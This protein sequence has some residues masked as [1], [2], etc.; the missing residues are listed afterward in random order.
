GWLVGLGAA[1]VSLPA[2]AQDAAPAAPPPPAPAMAPAPMA[3]APMPAAAAPT[4]APDAAKSS[5]TVGGHIGVATSFVTF[6]SE[7]KTIGDRFGLDNPIGV[8]VKFPSG[9]VVDFET[10]V[11]T[12]VLPK[13]STGFT[14][15]PGVVYNWGAVATGLRIASHIGQPAN[16]G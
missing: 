15:D 3:P 10:V 1:F 9:V 12:S 7:T 16:I 14:V 13:G 6:A 2:W 11:S 8:S 4:P 5:P